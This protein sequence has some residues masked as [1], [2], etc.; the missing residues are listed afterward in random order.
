MER[1]ITT[2]STGEKVFAGPIDDPFFV[3]LGGIFDLGD[4]PRQGPTRSED[5]L[6]CKNVSTLALEIDIT[7]L[8]KD[9]QPLSRAVNI[10]DGNYVIGVWASASRQKISILDEPRLNNYTDYSTVQ[11]QITDT[12]VGQW[13]QVSRLGMPLT[14]E[15]INPIGVK[16]LWN[17]LTPYDDLNNLKTFDKFFYNPESLLSGKKQIII[18]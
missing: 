1:A 4:A 17:R 11:N 3:D 7:T 12:H 15:V 9:H 2:S 6:K 10:L 18:F 13:V 14:N 16:D 8:Q 5:G